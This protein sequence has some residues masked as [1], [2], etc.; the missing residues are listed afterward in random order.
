M[1]TKWNFFKNNAIAGV[2]CPVPYYIYNYFLHAHPIFHVINYLT[3]DKINFSMILIK[4]QLD[5]K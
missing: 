5:L 4:Y 2:P 3:F 1:S